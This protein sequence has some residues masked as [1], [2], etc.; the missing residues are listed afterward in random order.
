MLRARL[1]LDIDHAARQWAQAGWLGAYVAP[2]KAR[3]RG[4]YSGWLAVKPLA[5][6]L[7]A[8]TRAASALIAKIPPALSRYVA[9]QFW[10]LQAGR[11]ERAQGNAELNTTDELSSE[12][13]E[14]SLARGRITPERN[15]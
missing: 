15:P 6:E 7:F 14:I 13:A 5:I 10:P 8:G 3:S 11:M 4:R 1:L 12:L 9:E 2:S